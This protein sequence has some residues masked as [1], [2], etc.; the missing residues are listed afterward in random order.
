M[1]KKIKP[2]ASGNTLAASVDRFCEF[3]AEGIHQIQ[4]AANEY[5]RAVSQWPEAEA[6]YK[7]RLPMFQRK[8]WMILARIGRG[9][10][11][12]R[13][14][15]LPNDKTIDAVHVFPI[16]VQE[17][18]VGTV[19]THPVPQKV[20]TRGRVIEKTVADM[21]AVEIATL[22][23]KRGARI[24]S[25]EEQMNAASIAAQPAATWEIRGDVLY[26]SGRQEIPLAEIDKV[27]RA[28]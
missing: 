20:F 14:F 19:N 27:R 3:F 13:A 9:E 15:Y 8:D 12:P 17:A 5:A 11:T 16:H 23:D 24:R 21:N 18:L 2:Q 25:V 4:N 22:I 10:L 7:K 1:S 6:E 26:V 28:K